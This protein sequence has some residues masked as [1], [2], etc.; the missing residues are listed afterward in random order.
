MSGVS[1]ERQRLLETLGSPKEIKYLA[2]SLLMSLINPGRET[3]P[4]RGS[5]SGSL[6]RLRAPANLHFLGGLQVGLWEDVGWRTG[7]LGPK[8]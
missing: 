3:V 7:R 2:L 4:T 1:W 8:S 5:P 6:A